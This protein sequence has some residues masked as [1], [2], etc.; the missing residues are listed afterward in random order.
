MNTLRANEGL[1]TSFLET[2]TL[3]PREMR[4]MAYS[5]TAESQGQAPGFRPAQRVPATSSCRHLT[6]GAMWSALRSRI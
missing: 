2:E 4:S 1:I 6:Q 3:Q 5:L